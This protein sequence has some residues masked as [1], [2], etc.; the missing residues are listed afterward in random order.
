[1][2]DFAQ[3]LGWLPTD[4]FDA[5]ELTDSTT[6]H[7]LVEHGLE[8][9][10]VISF[11]R[12]P[13]RYSDLSIAEVQRLLAI[14]YNNL[15]DWHIQV[16]SDEVLYVFNRLDPPRVVESF[17]ISRRE[18]KSLRSDAFE[19]VT[20]A[21]PNPNV[22]GLDDALIRTISFWKRNLAA[23]LGNAISNEQ[24]SALFN[25]LIFL[26]AAEDNAKRHH[27]SAGQ[28]RLL[29]DLF[30]DEERQ[31]NK[32]PFAEEI[33]LAL[34]RYMTGPIPDYVFDADRLSG[35]NRLDTRTVRAVV[36]DF[37]QNKYAPYAYDFSLMSK[38]ALSRI[39]EHYVS[40]LRLEDNRQLD[41]LPALPGEKK[42]RAFGSIYTPQFVA[43]FFAR[44][45][46]EQMPPL[47]FR[48][49]RSLDPACGSG[50]FLRSLLELQC[51]PPDELTTDTIEGCFGNVSGIDRDH[52]A[53]QATRLSLALLHLVLTDKLPPTLDIRAVEILEYLVAHPEKLR[54]YDAVI[55]NPPFVATVYQ[56]PEIR[57]RLT[58][59]MGEH[60]SGRVD[61]YLAFLRLAVESLRPG[62]F[63]LFVL[64]HN[65]LLAKSASGMRQFLREKCWIRCLVDLKEVTVFEG[66][67]SYV[68]LLVFQ[69]KVV[70]F[71]SEPKAFVVKCQDS[72]ARA[73]SC[74]IQGQT[75]DTSTASVYE[76][77]QSEFEQSEW[78]V[79]PPVEA[80]LTRKLAVLPVLSDFLEVR[81]GFISGADDVFLVPGSNI[82]RGEKAVYVPHLADRQMRPY[83]V[84]GKTERWLFYPF[85]GKERL[86]ERD[87]RTKFSRT[88]EYLQSHRSRLRNRPA[89]QKGNLEWWMPERPRSPM[90]ML[91]PKI[92]TPHLVLVPRFALDR[93]GR[94]A[95]SHSPYLFSTSGGADDDILRFFLAVLNST[96]C[97]WH[98]STHSY[99][100]LRGYARL[101]AATL[102]RTRVV[103][104]SKVDHATMRQTI[105]L[106]DRRLGCED[107]ETAE[108]LEREIDTVVAELYG[109]TA[110]ERKGIGM[111]A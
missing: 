102:S 93:D 47:V 36:G 103:D 107:P 89:V 13:R 38:H 34:K 51:E 97:F 69:K 44:Y 108:K 28:P 83:V 110:K 72:V 96:I 26:R 59:Y 15:V 63:G 46:R 27:T 67:G 64:P 29:L 60:A 92:V 14:S 3:T 22:P 50:L 81:L 109:L 73:L 33:G 11:F 66:V 76:V 70:P 48:R 2:N 57:A 52:N 41:L 106:V 98:V 39:Y 35:F 105:R 12:Y 86:S 37:Y 95:V 21:R 87:V 17:L 77:P 16:Q 94:Y 91:R 8:H 75:L 49:I 54:N 5:Q 45:L 7:L 55:A 111:E 40:I 61:L 74:V 101:E 99:S 10:A 53:C 23:E 84:P 18:A 20:G 100:Y 19:Q 43:R 9:T 78:H 68:V 62:G 42:D 56:E 104:P 79:L 85:E 90:E 31:R 1:L 25:T 82:P 30:S 6:A 65:F 32:R 88:W 80:G 58:A 71:V 4:R 24:L